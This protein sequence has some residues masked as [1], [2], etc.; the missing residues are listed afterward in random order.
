VGS[1]I[2]ARATPDGYTLL[3]GSTS[4]LSINPVLF[5]KLAYKP[6][7]FAAFLKRE[8]AKWAKA[9]KDSGV[10]VAPTVGLDLS[11]TDSSGGRRG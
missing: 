9:V 4:T 1:E 10:H 5:S 11:G 6:T 2:A 7:D 3:M 8:G